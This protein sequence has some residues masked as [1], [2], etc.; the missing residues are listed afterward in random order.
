MCDT[1][2]LERN[3]EGET[4]REKERWEVGIGTKSDCQ[5]VLNSS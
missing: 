5:L 1:L 4:E 3:R 2:S